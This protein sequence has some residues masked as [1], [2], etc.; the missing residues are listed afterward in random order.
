MIAFSP[1]ENPLPN[2][3][4]TSPRALVSKNI[5]RSLLSLDFKGTNLGLDL[6]S[7]LPIFYV[8]LRASLDLNKAIVGVPG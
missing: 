4:I 2:L 5:E 3:A 7:L 8:S 6:F 1:K